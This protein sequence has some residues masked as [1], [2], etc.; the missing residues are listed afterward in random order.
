VILEILILQPQKY[1]LSV[2]QSDKHSLHNEGIKNINFNFTLPCN[3]S[4]DVSDEQT[5]GENIDMGVKNNH[6][7]CCQTLHNP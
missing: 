6:F 7:L 1:S 3:N 4:I 5:G 2:L